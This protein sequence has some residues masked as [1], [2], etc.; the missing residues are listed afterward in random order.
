MKT[1][2]TRLTLLLVL[3]V[4]MTSSF[5]LGQK[6]AR[7]RLKPNTDAIYLYHT[8][9]ENG[10]W[11]KGCDNPPDSCNLGVGN[12]GPKYTHHWV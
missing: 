12:V 9:G 4:A 7:A 2:K 8:S 5:A 11:V 1:R 10:R 3:V 6:T